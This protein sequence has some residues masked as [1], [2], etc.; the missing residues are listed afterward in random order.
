MTIKTNLDQRDFAKNNFPR[1]TSNQPYS[2]ILNFNF[3]QML[4]YIIKYYYNFYLDEKK[5]ISLM[6]GN[7]IQMLFREN[8]G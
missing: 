4:F 3:I 6:N 5:I 2:L 8:N 7:S 1:K